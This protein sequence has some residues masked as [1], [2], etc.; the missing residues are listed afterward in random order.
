MCIRGLILKSI[1]LIIWGLLLTTSVGFALTTSNVTGGGKGPSTPA[2]INGT[3]AKSGIP[4]MAVGKSSNGVGMRSHSRVS[5]AFRALN[6]NGIGTV[7]P[8]D[9][10]LPSPEPTV[11]ENGWRAEYSAIP[12]R[13]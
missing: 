5:S 3:P 2:N 7:D 9:A 4:G 1:L 6:L 12:S 10:S 13:P 8:S 11:T